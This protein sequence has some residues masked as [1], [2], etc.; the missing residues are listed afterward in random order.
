MAVMVRTRSNTRDRFQDLFSFKRVNVWCNTLLGKVNQ[1][2]LTQRSTCIRIQIKDMFPGPFVPFFP[3]VSPTVFP[4][5]CLDT[6]LWKIHAC[7]VA[8]V[9]GLEV[10]LGWGD[11]D[12]FEGWVYFNLQGIIHL[13]L[14]FLSPSLL[15]PIPLVCALW[16]RGARWK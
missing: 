5:L 3:V 8:C 10:W 14:L 9:C 11:A 16:T 15:S 13:S 4:P 1:I 12:R 2:M 6:R 7:S